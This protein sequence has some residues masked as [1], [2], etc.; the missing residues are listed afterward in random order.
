MF[1]KRR[2]VKSDVD[3]AITEVTRSGGKAYSVGSKTDPTTERTF[4][5]IGAA[6][7]Y[8]QELVL[9]RVSSSLRPSKRPRAKRE[10][11]AG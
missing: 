8:F 10:A 7:A 11:R 5:D 1:P 9:R 6:K 2:T 4:G 3:I